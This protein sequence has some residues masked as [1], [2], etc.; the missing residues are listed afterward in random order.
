M[1][2]PEDA[3]PTG[4]RAAAAAMTTLAETLDR[5]DRRS[6]GQTVLMLLLVAVIVLNGLVAIGNHSVGT[7]I[8]DC[9][10]PSGQCAQQSRQRTSEVQRGIIESQRADQDRQL[11]ALCTLTIE[12]EL[13]VPAE[14]AAVAVPPGTL[15]R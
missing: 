7:T 11:R 14:C 2:G 12:H 9:I 3:D 1:R 10:N 13:K 15:P 8:E 5:V 4:L 6:K